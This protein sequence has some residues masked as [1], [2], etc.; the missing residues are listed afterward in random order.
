MDNGNENREHYIVA[1]EGRD[2]IVRQVPQGSCAHTYTKAQAWKHAK[3]RRE[4]GNEKK[5]IQPGRLIFVGLDNM[6][7]VIEWPTEETSE[8]ALDNQPESVHTDPMTN[9]TNV[10]LHVLARQGAEQI[11]GMEMNRDTGEFDRPLPRVIA[12]KAAQSVKQPTDKQITLFNK[13]CTQIKGEPYTAG[14]AA[15]VDR[16]GASAAINAALA[17]I[18]E[19]KRVAAGESMPQAQV[20][21]QPTTDVPA[22]RYAIENDEG[23]LGF[24]QVDRP[25]E[26]RWAGYTFVKYQASDET[27]PVRDKAKRDRILSKIAQ[28]VKEAMLTYGREIGA[29]GHCGRTLTDEDSRN[30]GI[31]PVCAG[32]VSWA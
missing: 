6:R 25:T 14:F 7:M 31:G 24:F 11:S 9:T 17:I 12:P 22:G 26:G 13:L 20:S 19:S 5:R 18:K 4:F 32:K 21:A 8:S 3:L 15:T 28:N 27:Y 2:V 10:P 29:C 1:K 16:K 23:T 30:A